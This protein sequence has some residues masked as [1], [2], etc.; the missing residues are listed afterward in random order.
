MTS[1][2]RALWALSVL[3]SGKLAQQEWGRGHLPELALDAHSAAG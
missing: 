2:G 3:Q 1:L